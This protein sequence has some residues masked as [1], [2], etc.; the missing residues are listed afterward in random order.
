MF[1]AAF[2]GPLLLLISMN[3]IMYIGIAF[4][5]LRYIC[6]RRRRQQL[7]DHQNG[8]SAKNTTGNTATVFRLWCIL[9]LFGLTWMFGAF[10]ITQTSSMIFSTLFAVFTSMQGFFI[11]VFLC[12]LSK[13]ALTCYKALCCRWSESYRTSESRPPLDRSTLSSSL[14]PKSPDLNFKLQLPIKDTT[15]HA[16]AQELSA[17]VMLYNPEVDTVKTSTFKPPMDEKPNSFNQ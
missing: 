4:V 8:T 16:L 9:C 13:D 3:I 11:F 15:K 12:L 1:F 17:K 7:H 5:Q 6:Y 2:L 10:T 14:S